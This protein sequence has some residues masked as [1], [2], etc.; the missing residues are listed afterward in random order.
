MLGKSIVTAVVRRHSHD[1]TR[2]VSC[3]Y[4]VAYPDGNCLTGKGIDGIASGEYTGNATVG[5]TFAFGT[6]LGAFQ[7]S[8]YFIFLC[9]GGKLLYQFAFGSQYHEGDAEHGICTGGEDSEF[10]I[11]V[12]YLE[13]YFSAF[14][15]SYP[16]LLGFFQGFGPV[17]GIESV[18][19]AL[20]IGRYTETPLTHLLLNDGEAASFAYAVHHFIVGKYGSQL[21]APVY[22]RLAQIGYTVVHQDFLLFFF[23]LGIPLCGGETQFFAASHVHS[24]GT[25]LAE[26]F[27]QFLDGTCLLFIVAVVAVEH[28]LEC[29]LGPMVIFRFAGTDFAVPVER[30]TYLIQLFTVSVDIVDGRNCRVLSRL[31]GIL[32]CWKSVSVIS[33]GI[34]YIETLQSFVAGVNIRSNISQR[35]TYMQS[36][37]GGVGEHVQYIEF[38][39]RFVFRHLVG[40]VFHPPFLPFLFNFPE[41]VFHSGTY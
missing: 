22:H 1:G 6:F 11:A 21:R 25:G 18:Q 31:Y 4:I 10:Q 29:P 41:I 40:F 15:A 30:E 19:Q 8:V 23:A 34:Q 32:F 27:N 28:L 37:T 2:T 20:C 33:H 38:F 17:D 13:F 39:L 26:C 12:F 5:N 35:M 16:V 7:I 3:K 14:A 24:F 9:V 36:R